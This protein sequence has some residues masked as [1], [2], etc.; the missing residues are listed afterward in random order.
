MSALKEGAVRRSA[1]RP[2]LECGGT[3]GW[4]VVLHEGEN[5]ASDRR[6]AYQGNR[7]FSA[8]GRIDRDQIPCADCS[9]RNE[10]TEFC[11]ALQRGHLRAKG[12]TLA[13]ESR[14]PDQI[15]GEDVKVW[16][17][18]R[19]FAQETVQVSPPER[20]R[21]R[22]TGPLAARA[23][24]ASSICATSSWSCVGRG[25]RRKTPTGTGKSGHHMRLRICVRVAS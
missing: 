3:K 1:Q 5:T 15:V 10:V 14:R 4:I 22:S 17:A 9:A 11:N 24:F 8:R 12:A 2:R 18:L 13:G 25:T 23:A 20:S 21:C 6:L 19:L 16:R 7:L